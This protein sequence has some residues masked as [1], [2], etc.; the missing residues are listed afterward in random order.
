MRAGHDERVVQHGTPARGAEDAALVGNRQRVVGRELRRLVEL[1]IEGRPSGRHFSAL[2]ADLA[3]L[4]QDFLAIL[5]GLGRREAER[6]HQLRVLANLVVAQNHQI[7]GRVLH[8][9][10]RNPRHRDVAVRRAVLLEDPAHQEH[11]PA[12]VVVVVREGVVSL[13]DEL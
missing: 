1:R 7:G 4:L 6:P 3:D 9:L 5:H 11:E 2:D 12:I 10:V 8:L 13:R